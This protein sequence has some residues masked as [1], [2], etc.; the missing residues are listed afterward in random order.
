MGSA[1]QTDANGFQKVYSGVNPTDVPTLRTSRTKFPLPKQLRDK[2][3]GNQLIR[4][5]TVSSVNKEMVDIEAVSQKPLTF[6][7][8]GEWVKFPSLGSMV[9]GAGRNAT[10][11]SVLAN[12][13]KFAPGAEKVAD[14]ATRGVFGSSTTSTIGT[15]KMWQ[16]SDPLRMS[17]SLRFE[18]INDANTEVL[19]P[20][21]KLLSLPL[22]SRSMSFLGGSDFFL[23]PPGPAPFPDNLVGKVM[24]LRSLGDVKNLGKS[25]GE[26]TTVRFGGI[27]TIRRVLVIDVSVKWDQRCDAVGTPLA[28]DLDLI[29][30][31]SEVMTKESLYEA[32]L[33]VSK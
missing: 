17:V 33:G 29:F 24:N 19:L 6:N 22:P 21:L 11:G 10:P 28:A 31:S 32:M 18:A 13:S 26:Q 1:T 5:T 2:I 7:S 9:S 14:M 23:V 16:G 3:D 25:T 12:Y 20:A 8:K 30:E 27:L 4:I 15:R